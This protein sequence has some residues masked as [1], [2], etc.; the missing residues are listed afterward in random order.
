LKVLHHDAPPEARD[1]CQP[2]FRA[3]LTDLGIT[4]PAE[5]LVRCDEVEAF[6]PPVWEVTEEIMTRNSRIEP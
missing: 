2:G 5:W 6:L 1:H 3:L 4:S